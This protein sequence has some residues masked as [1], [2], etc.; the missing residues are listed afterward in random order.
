MANALTNGALPAWIVYRS[1]FC[2]PDIRPQG[3]SEGISAAYSPHGN[4]C[5][6]VRAYFRYFPM[7]AQFIMAT[8]RA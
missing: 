1:A 5:G 2:R 4:L 8:I 7:P 3:E 6:E